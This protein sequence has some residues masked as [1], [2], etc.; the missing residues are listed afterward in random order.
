M[1]GL[2]MTN[3]AF[4]P[5]AMFNVAGIGK[6]S[7]DTHSRIPMATEPAGANSPRHL[8]LTP[9]KDDIL[10]MPVLKNARHELFAQRV[11]K[12]E[13]LDA[14]YVAAGYRAHKQNPARLRGKDVVSG[15]IAEILQKI[16]E[17]TIVSVERLRQE[18]A[19]VGMADITDVL[20]FKGKTVRIKDSS[21]L[22]PDIT[23]AIAEVQQTKDGIRIKMHPKQPALDALGRHIG[24]FKENINLNVTVSLVDLVMASYPQPE[25][26]KQIE[27][28]VVK[29]PE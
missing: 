4:G 12:G 1:A 25:A 8:T 16:E 10:E 17:R 2:A 3:R 18:Y 15:R 6:R 19:R 27:G 29:V 26:P 7:E 28:T 13:T 9:C 20:S 14:A 5:S 23:A 11:A 24:M 22:S 21:T